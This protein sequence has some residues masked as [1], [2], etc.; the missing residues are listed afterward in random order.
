MDKILKIPII[1]WFETYPF[2][3][4]FNHLLR[5]KKMITLQI[6]SGASAVTLKLCKGNQLQNGWMNPAYENFLF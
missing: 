5:M 1:T 3:T 2:S 4:L 6:P